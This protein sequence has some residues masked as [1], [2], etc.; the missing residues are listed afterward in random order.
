MRCVP[1]S[2]RLRRSSLG[3]IFFNCSLEDFAKELEKKAIKLFKWYELKNPYVA[4]KGYKF[5]S[6]DFSK[7]EIVYSN[8]KDSV[9]LPMS[10]MDKDLK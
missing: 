8:G 3:K 4:N 1:Y 6:C 7:S 2:Y 9:R 5:K 10:L